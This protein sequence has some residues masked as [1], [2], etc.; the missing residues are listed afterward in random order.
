MIVGTTW[1]KFL[2]FLVGVPELCVIVC[3][4]LLR[5]QIVVL[6]GAWMVEGLVIGCV[7]MLIVSQNDANK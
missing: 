4:L 6:G 7:N 2:L 3:S 1:L 5:D